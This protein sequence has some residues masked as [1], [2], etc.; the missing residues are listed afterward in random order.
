MNLARPP[1]LWLVAPLLVLSAVSAAATVGA[2]WLAGWPLLLV[3][4]SPRL[5]FLAIA[6]PQVGLVPFL[7]VGTF[8]LCAGDPFHFL[9]G[10][11]VAQ[12]AAVQS[13]FRRIAGITRLAHRPN[14]KRAAAVAVLMRP[15][16]RHLALAGAAGVPAG[17]VTAL[18]VA[19]TL[20]YLAAV[21]AGG[22]FL[23]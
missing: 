10:R 11:R 16:G 4:L 21:R 8:R 13:R 1:A 3:G 7:L 14:S 5:P 23:L 20:A 22:S 12:G 15:I 2:P 18:D 17:V 6:A 9:L 19:G